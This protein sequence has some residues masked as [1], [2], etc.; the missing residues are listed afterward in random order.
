ML[1]KMMI[2]IILIL[3]TTLFSTGIDKYIS[4]EI[5]SRED[6]SIITKLVSIDNREGNTLYAY[7]LPDEIEALENRGIAYKVLTHPRDKRAVLTI[8]TDI[9][10]MSNWDR[11]P[12]FEVYLELMNSFATNYPEICSIQNIGYSQNNREIP[13]V[14]ITSNVTQEAAKPGF[15]YSGQMHGDELVTYILLLRLIDELLTNYDTNTQITNLLDNTEIWINPLANP[16]GTYY[17]GNDDVS[18]A[19]RYLANNLDPN[20]NFIDFIDGYPGTGSSTSVSQENLDQIAFMTGKGIVM[21]ANTHGGAELVNYPWDTIPGLHPDDTWFQQI[22][23]AYADAVH[24][25]APSTYMDGYDDGITNGYDWYE[26]NGSRQDYVVYYLG[27]KEITIEQSN[28]KMVNVGDLNAHWTYNRDALLALM[29][30]VHYGIKGFVTD[31]Q[32]NPLNATIEILNH[33]TDVTKVRTNPDFGDYYRPINPGTYDIQISVVGYDPLVFSDVTVTANSAVTVDAVF[34]EPELN[35]NIQLNTGWNLISYNLDYQDNSP[36]NLFSSVL[37]NV[38]EIKNLTKT[39]SPTLPDYF[40]T[41]NNMIPQEGYWVNVSDDCT[42][43]L[44][45]D[46]YDSSVSIDLNSGWNLIGYLPQLDVAPNEAL[47]NILDK[48]LQVKD[49][50]S[51]YN[52]TMP[53]V[54]N[55][56]EVMT[57]NKGYWLQVSEDCTLV[58]NQT[59]AAKS[60]QRE[61]SPWN[62]TIYPNNT[63]VIYAE[64]SSSV[65]DVNP[66]QDFVGVFSDGECLG[67]SMLNLINEGNAERYAVSIVTQM[68]ASETSLSFAYYKAN[69]AQ[70]IFLEQEL[71]VQ[72]GEIYGELPDNLIQLNYLITEND[73]DNDIEAFNQIL[74]STGTNPFRDNLTINIDSKKE[75]KVEISLYNLKGQKVATKTS[76]VSPNEVENIGINTKEIASG[77]YFVKVK[78]CGKISTL[79]VVKIK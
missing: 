49:L 14:K 4:I 19:R 75:D 38:S 15:Y 33:D 62:I 18:G 16:D 70:T 24:E 43:E 25:D 48:L 22:S 23:R 53:D 63:A 68:P 71:T 2:L 5:S 21:S 57:P 59:S 51:I 46:A 29:E 47:S 34:G 7:A 69:S 35:Q 10:Q 1:K 3:T 40:N 26:A 28:T 55:T 17:G 8:A 73:N 42:L 36:S 27:I 41:L 79:K 45:E 39:Y 64:F 11:Y 32:G 58:Y 50:T 74:I 56:L 30:E 20:R 12:T 65:I 9:T 31:A 13:V 44:T 54:F 72:S 66:N 60:P 37:E 76:R 6:I 78:S 67:A 77:I 61:N 52:P